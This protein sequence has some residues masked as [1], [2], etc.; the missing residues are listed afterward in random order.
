MKSS[1]RQRVRRT[2]RGFTVLELMIVISIAA[3]LLV[4]GIPAFQDFGMRQR[5]SAAIQLLHTHLVL[6][7]HEAINR[8]ADIIICPGDTERACTDSGDWSAG[9]L[10]FSDLNGDR[11]YQAGETLHRAEP[12]LEQLVIHSSSGRSSLRFYPNGSAPGSNGSITF[13]DLRGPAHARKLVI[14]NIGRIRRDEA[15]E[16]DSQYCPT[17]DG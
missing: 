11:Q 3:I 4:M 10:V 2:A 1:C 12:G 7:R 16:L 9:W 8:N 13:C 5:M 17:V 14:S 15:P 6:A